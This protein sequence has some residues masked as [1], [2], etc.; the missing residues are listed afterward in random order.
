MAIVLRVE[1]ASQVDERAQSNAA[2]QRAAMAGPDPLQG[3]SGTDKGVSLCRGK[4]S[5]VTQDPLLISQLKSGRPTYAKVG[6]NSRI[7]H[8][9]ASGQG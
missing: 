2:P 4:S 8:D 9:S 1:V 7:Q 5:E 3:C 6:I